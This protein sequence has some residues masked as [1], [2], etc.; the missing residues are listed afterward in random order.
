VVAIP[1]SYE[2]LDG[3]LQTNQVLSVYFVTVLLQSLARRA[4]RSVELQTEVNALNRDLS[5]ERDQLTHALR[6]L[7][8]AQTRLVENEKMATQGQ[9]AA[10]VAHELNNPVAAIQ[11]AADFM[12]KDVS[13]LVA[14]HPDVVVLSA[15]LG[16]AVTRPPLSTREERRLRSELTEALGGDERLARRLVRVGIDSAEAYRQHLDAMSSK[17][18]ETNLRDIEHYYRLGASLK[19]IQT[20]AERITA[21]VKS[22]RSYARTKHEITAGVDVRTG[23]EETLLLFGHEMRRIEVIR[24]YGD[25][26][27]IQC[28][29]GEIN[30]VW[31]NLVSN[32]IEAMQGEGTLTL[33][34]AAPGPDRIE[35]RVTDSGAGI[36]PENLEHIF[37]VNFTTR[38]GPAAFGLGIGLPICREI[39]DRHGGSLAVESRPGRTT[40]TVALPARQQEGEDPG[41]PS[42]EA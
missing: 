35:V 16:N 6:R 40:F 8:S 37:D 19:N 39:I 26:P 1:V 15:V 42:M 23:L 5:E 31:T 38:Q 22:L 2:D 14:R 28:H 20:C 34:A 3:A 32:A 7:E 30:Q 29:P 9:L 36:Q 13:A 24:H 27:G 12:T 25:L 33:E 4:R 11:R 21:L 10:G 41:T 18:P 17:N